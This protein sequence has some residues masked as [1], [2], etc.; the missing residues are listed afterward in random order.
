[1]DTIDINIMKIETEKN[2][3]AILY[4]EGDYRCDICDEKGNFNDGTMFGIGKGS[5]AINVC[6]VCLKT[7][8]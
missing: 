5:S 6:E 4:I 2:N 8:L 1:M 3:E 7:Q